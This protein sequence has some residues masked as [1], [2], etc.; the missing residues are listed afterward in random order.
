MN[1]ARREE[2][3]AGLAGT[4]ARIRDACRAAGRDRS[5]VRLI[6]VTKTY[7]AS[8]VRLLAGLGVTDVGENRDQEAAPK[9]SECADLDL[10]W[11]FIGQLQTNK[12]RSVV[13]YADMV[14][15]V[16]RLRLVDALSREAVRAGREI[17]CLLQ[18]SLD[19]VPPA[20]GGVAERGGVAPEAVPE[21]AEAVARA[22]NLRLRGVMAVAPLG[23]DPGPAFARLAE[24]ARAL[25]NDHPGADVVSA[26]MSGDL[27][28]AIANGATH[29]R[30]GT[31]LL[32]RRKPFV[33]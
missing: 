15:S 13:A 16:D 20:P 28:E 31:A 23:E 12:V 30:V 32:G 5:E 8:D 21:L 10:T 14:H 9:A 11:H 26:G 24:I 2:L 7:P 3:A 22:E 25:R 17:G 1:D 6:A 29:V 27:D 4:E 19:P 18:V 33:R